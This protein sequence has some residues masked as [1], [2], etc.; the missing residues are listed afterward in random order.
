MNETKDARSGEAGPA[1][2]QHLLNRGKTKLQAIVA[3]MRKLL[4]AIF[5]M[6]KHDQLFDG[7]KIYA[8]ETT[9]A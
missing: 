3:V 1:F 4:H 5:G 8:M 6:F 2:Y 9:C 7:S